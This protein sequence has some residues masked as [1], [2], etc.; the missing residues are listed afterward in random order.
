MRALLLGFAAL[1]PLL[2]LA[3]I[4]TNLLLALAPL[5]ASHMLMLYATLTANS[6]WWGRVVTSFKTGAPE[7]WITVDD[8]PSQHTAAILEILDRYGARAT[9]FVIGERAE[10]HPHLVTEILARGHALANHTFSHP[11]ATFWCAGAARIR[12]EIDRCAEPLRTTPDRPARW[13]RAPAGMKN[14]F[15]HPILAR[16]GLS[17]IG[18]TARG[19][20]TVARDATRVA[21]RIERCAQ[22]GAII[23]LHE[24]QR[25]KRDPD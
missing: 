15:V 5:F 2:S 11:R 19:L 1:A 25:L 12:S 6:Q 3:L 23:L 18:W 13:F 10:R 9:F 22:P 8:G 20:D 24:G 21:E 14:F 17:L 7:V 4:G 16:R